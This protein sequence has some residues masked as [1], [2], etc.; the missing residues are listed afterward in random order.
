MLV[1]QLTLLSN[2]VRAHMAEVGI[3]G[4][5]GVH[6]IVID[7]AQGRSTDMRDPNLIV[8]GACAGKI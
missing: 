1:R 4:R 7:H 8:E 2:T 6:G 5:R 3:V